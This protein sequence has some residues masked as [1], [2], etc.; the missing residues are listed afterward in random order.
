MN[1][2]FNCWKSRR[3]DSIQQWLDKMFARDGSLAHR[4][5]NAPNLAVSMGV[6]G[7][8]TLS[9]ESH[10]A[11]QRNHFAE[12]WKGEVLDMQSGTSH[13]QQLHEVKKSFCS[14]FNKQREQILK[15]R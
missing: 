9:T 5:G 8:G 10:L 7:D 11:E 13:R 15:E 14:I 3:A 1:R 6:V 2:V 4:W 12:L